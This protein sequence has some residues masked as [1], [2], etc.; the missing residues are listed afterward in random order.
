MHSVYLLVLVLFLYPKSKYLFSCYQSSSMN[1]YL[2]Q[3]L[4]HFCIIQCQ[5]MKNLLCLSNPILYPEYPHLSMSAFLVKLTA[6]NKIIFQSRIIP[7]INVYTY[8]ISNVN[9]Y[10]FSMIKC[11]FILF[12]T[13]STKFYSCFS[14]III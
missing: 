14:T 1:S 12:Q 2:L 6:P 9:V 5:E 8:L 7:N 11:N 10:N 13:T 4:L 3:K